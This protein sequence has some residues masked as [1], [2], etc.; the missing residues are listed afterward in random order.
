MLI[1]PITEVRNPRHIIDDEEDETIE[2]PNPIPQITISLDSKLKEYTNILIVPNTLSL[3]QDQLPNQK[4]IGIINI[5]YKDLKLINTENIEEYD[6][7]EQLYVSIQNE[8]ILKKYPNLKIPIYEIEDTITFNIPHF[9]N[10][11]TY[12]LLS[13]EIISQFKVK[14]ENWV[15]L[16]HSTL[17]NNQSINQLSSTNNLVKDIP[18]LKPPH[19]IT[20][21]NASI[22]TH[23][24]PSTKYNLLVLNSEGQFGFEKS[25]NESVINSSYVLVNLLHIKNQKEYLKNVSLKI[26]KFNGYSNLGMYI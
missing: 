25:D 6:E 5:D 18:I 20:G 9:T 1:K 2:Q 12:N 11:I 21:I 4:Q 19:S 10:V 17:N 22:I 24:P 16:S 15:L 14:V 3:L 7:D 26:R 8:S 23:L 13:K